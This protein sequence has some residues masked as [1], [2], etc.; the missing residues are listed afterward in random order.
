MVHIELSSAFFPK[1][2]GRP[3]VTRRVS[4]AQGRSTLEANMHF[5]S[6]ANRLHG[7]LLHGA[8]SWL[9]ISGLLHFGIDVVSQYIP[10]K[11]APSSATTLYYGLNSSY[12]VSQILFAAL[13]LF[14]IRQGV[15]AMG[16][17]SGV[18][19]GLL[20]AC[21]WFVLS[22]LF[23]EYPQPRMTVALFA[24]LLVGVALTV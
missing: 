9:L 16:Q 2:S 4:S 11:R 15:T 22:L 5:F 18:L 24:A 21:A 14:A 20:A 17:W 6:N 12:A 8:Y 13:A 7:L 19:L 23:L 10:G 3:I 1:E